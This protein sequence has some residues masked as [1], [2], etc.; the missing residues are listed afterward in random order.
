M[1]DRPT[2]Y[3]ITPPMGHM[4][5]TQ[6]FSIIKA[7]VIVSLFASVTNYV[8]VS[9]AA[10]ALS[11]ALL[12]FALTRPQ[13]M[14]PI[15]P[16]V[17]VLGFFFVYAAIYHYPQLFDYKFYRRDGNVFVTMAPLVFIAMLPAYYDLDNI[18]RRFVYF[19]TAV[20]LVVLVF[21]LFLDISLFRQFATEN[22]RTAVYHFLFVAHNA[23]GGFLAVLCCFSLSNLL[24]RRSLLH[25]TIFLVN[26]GGLAATNSRGSMIGFVVACIF[27]FLIPSLGRRPL[28]T[29]LIILAL[30]LAAVAYFYS[31]TDIE[32]VMARQ[33]RIT[34]VI[35]NLSPS[36]QLAI[37]GNISNRVEVL[38]PMAFHA[39]QQS[40]VL[41]IGFGA[42]NDTPWQ[43]FGL[44]GVF[45]VNQSPSVVHSD[46]H[47]HHT[48]LHVMA[49]TGLV[50]L[51]LLVWMIK[52]LFEFV[53]SIEQPLVGR[54][55][56]LAL[57]TGV[58][59]SFTEHRFFTPS[60]MF[61]FVLVCAMALANARLA[62]A[63]SKTG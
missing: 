12:P 33:I 30:N 10:S 36:V 14:R 53:R 59:A 29:F 27:V 18:L 55:L 47:A 26:F 9:A 11:L 44:N 22:D 62:V 6:R 1:I 51:F 7:V 61:P 21:W 35:G 40:P 5:L 38:W 19:A 41:G 57:W 43:F 50:G 58:I 23:G 17:V 32:L 31:I 24:S 28:R 4:E 63:E 3:P 16:I 56:E 52:R 2:I 49:E 39:F 54:A 45:S 34:S 25:L 13:F 46:F 37:D 60:Q 42:Y 8:A 48:Y 15:V 20:N